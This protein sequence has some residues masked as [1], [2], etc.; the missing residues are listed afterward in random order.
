MG[1]VDRAYSPLPKPLKG[2]FHVKHDEKARAKPCAD[3]GTKKVGSTAASSYDVLIDWGLSEDLASA[4]VELGVRATADSD[5]ISILTVALSASH[6]RT[7][8][9][10]EALAEAEVEVEKL[11]KDLDEL[12]ETY[13]E[14]V[15]AFEGAYSP[16]DF[17]R[18]SGKEEEGDF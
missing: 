4:I 9:C 17:P 11:Q 8:A 2:A 7:E 3:C 18:E 12:E 5:Q 10:R 6:E 14:A 15:A 16:V 13:N 1:G